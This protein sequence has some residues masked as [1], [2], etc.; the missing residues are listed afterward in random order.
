MKKN[1]GVLDRTIR[2]IIGLVAGLF[3]Y[4]G[5]VTGISFF[6]LLAVSGIFLLTSVVSFCPLYGLLGLHTCTTK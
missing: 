2:I 3:V 6:V 1:M 4:L 5:Y